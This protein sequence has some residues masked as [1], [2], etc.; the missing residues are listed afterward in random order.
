M[1]DFS[2][3]NEPRIRW[4]LAALALLLVWAV[5]VWH[6]SLEWNLNPQYTYGWAVPVLCLYLARLRYLDAPRTS[7]PWRS[8]RNRALILLGLLI[9]LYVP[10]IV[11]RV[12]NPEWRPLGYWI[13]LQAILIT[14]IGI[15]LS[16]GWR[17]AWHFLFP[18]GFFLVAV[19]W[20]RPIDAPLMDFLMQKNAGIAIEGLLW[21][22]FAAARKGNL[23]I[24]PSGTVGVDEACSGIRSLQGT[25]MLGLFLG[26]MFRLG[27]LR[28]ILLVASGAGIALLTNSVRT[29]WLARVAAQ[30]GEDAV[31]VWHDSAGYSILLS[32]FALLWVTALA[33]SRLP[34][35]PWTAVNA[36]WRYVCA[37]MGEDARGW[38]P[39]RPVWPLAVAV[40]LVTA[41][42]FS[43]WWY[44][45]GGLVAPP[46]VGWTVQ[47]P[48]E[49]TGYVK[50]EIPDKV[51]IDM[52]FDEGWTGSWKGPGDSRLQAWYLRW[53][54][55]R[56]STQLARMHD[57]RVCLGGLG[58][59]LEAELVTWEFRTNGLVLPVQSFR[60]K[61]AGQPVHVY[62]ALLDDRPAVR[63]EKRLD[64]S[65]V[66]RLWAAWEGRK[67][68]GQRLVEV[69]V[70]G[71]MPEV[72]ARRMVEQFLAESALVTG[73]VPAPL[74]SQKADLEGE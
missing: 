63:M 25:L 16:A 10:T 51:V 5:P 58:L 33:L 6:F 57:P 30:G 40:S 44:D 20:P 50:M 56:N 48:A 65:T 22:G 69:G 19:P 70:W 18:V 47:E 32:N 31:D 41:F 55:G 13:A 60:F 42:G 7:Y 43:A 45:R 8:H 52:R 61:D 34:A 11:V 17:V 71:D 23:V 2:L 54:P 1:P 14:L 4:W 36:W 24:L 68:R 21:E 3:L 49:K 35:M 27:V 9:A 26:E 59:E 72:E 73:Q 64:N 53:E 74:V 12:A 62:Y 39:I 46:T 37:E 66:S 67:H 28:R 38:R 29:F 15:Y